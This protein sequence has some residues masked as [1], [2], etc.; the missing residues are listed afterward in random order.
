MQLY[1]P[2]N[3]VG[4]GT[5]RYSFPNTSSWEIYVVQPSVNGA[6]TATITVRAVCAT[7]AVAARTSAAAPLREGI[8]PAAHGCAAG[9]AADR[10]E[11]GPAAA[12]G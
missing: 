10:R 11:H 5:P 3:F 9:G 8:K 12:P 4:L 7:S 2:T 6:T 1:S